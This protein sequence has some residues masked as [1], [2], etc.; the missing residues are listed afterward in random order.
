M[1]NGASEELKT[2]ESDAFKLKLMSAEIEARARATLANEQAMADY[3]SVDPNT[4]KTLREW[5]GIAPAEGPMNQA[6]ASAALGMGRSNNS[7]SAAEARRNANKFKPKIY[8]RDGKVVERSWET[9]PITGQPVAKE[10]ALGA[11]PAAY[12]K[13]AEYRAE[14]ESTYAILDDL[15]DGAKKLLT[16]DPWIKRMGGAAKIKLADMMGSGDPGLVDMVATLESKSLA[17]AAVIN[18]GRPSDTDKQ[19]VQSGLVKKTDT[20]DRALQKINA[21]R[22]VME[23]TD[24]SMHRMLIEGRMEPPKPKGHTT[25]DLDAELIKRGIDP[26]TGKPLAKPKG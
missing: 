3:N 22:G 8:S 9:D 17:I 24:S 2:Q 15:E 18:K 13:Y 16:N 20:L 12:N 19:A 7:L 26:A 4:S 14:A 23:R 1:A 21:L 6:S 5:S 10:S 25:E 11:T